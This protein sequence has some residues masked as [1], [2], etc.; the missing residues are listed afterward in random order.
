M[1]NHVKVKIDVILNNSLFK[2]TNDCSM[3]FDIVYFYY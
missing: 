3:L 2:I 1:K